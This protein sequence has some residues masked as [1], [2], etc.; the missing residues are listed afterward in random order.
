MSQ[1][2]AP[3]PRGPRAVPRRGGGHAAPLDARGLV[4][5]RRAEGRAGLSG[6]GPD[7]VESCGTPEESER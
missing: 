1:V 3:A 2:R 7:G 6:R 5:L 4:R